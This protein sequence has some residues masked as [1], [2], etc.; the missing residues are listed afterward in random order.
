[1][2]GTV[3]LAELLSAQSEVKACK[4]AAA[5][6]AKDFALM[7]S[8][9]SQGQIQLQAALLDVAQLKSA[10]S[11]MVPRGELEA[12]KQEF[13]ATKASM[14]AAE[15][16]HLDLIQSLQ[17]KLTAVEQEKSQLLKNAQVLACSSSM[18]E[19]C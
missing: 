18:L 8:Q 3:T 10:I 5:A 12:A 2:Q 14:R 17:D 15:Q 11:A 1:M 9:V 16:A 6:K 13:D 19:M 7:E 4:E